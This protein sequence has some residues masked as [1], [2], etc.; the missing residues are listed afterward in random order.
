MKSFLAISCVKRELASI[1]HFGDCLFGVCV[2]VQYLATNMLHQGKAI[3]KLSTNESRRVWTVT[4][5]S[6]G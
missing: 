6:H 2:S 3:K 1:W 5:P 4:P